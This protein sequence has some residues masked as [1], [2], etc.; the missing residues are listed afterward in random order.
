MK[1]KE[2][3][4]GEHAMALQHSRKL[5]DINK[6]EMNQLLAGLDAKLK[7]SQDVS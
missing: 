4:V 7:E 3:E 5:I 1:L 2:K 6:S